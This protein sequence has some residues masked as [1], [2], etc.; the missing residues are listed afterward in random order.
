MSA[1]KFHSRGLTLFE[2]LIVMAV[3]GILFVAST[4][5]A[6]AQMKKARDGK[7]KSDLN[8]IKVALYDYFFDKNCFPDSLPTCGEPLKLGE[9]VYLGSFPCDSQGNPY[10]YQTDHTGCL[11]FKVLTNLENT[12]DADIDRIG[13]RTGC[14]PNC[15]YNYGLASTNI[16]IYEGC[17]QY[18]ACNP[19]GQCQAYDN[20]SESDCP[21]TYKNDPNCNNFCPQSKKEGRCKTASGKNEPGSNEPA[22]K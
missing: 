8:R 14:G 1:Q 16:V 5:I 9:S 22:K 10:I 3:L 12:R 13:C 18:Y 11:W 6:S 7:R 20:P 19:G 4:L 17:V 21:T 2:L 15:Q